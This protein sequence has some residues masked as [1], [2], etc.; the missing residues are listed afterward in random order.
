MGDS[1]FGGDRD[2]LRPAKKK[3][4]VNVSNTSTKGKKK[5]AKDEKSSILD[6]SLTESSGTAD[7]T[8]SK[9]DPFS[10][11][12]VA[13]LESHIQ[14]LEEE[15]DALISQKELMITDYKHKEEMYQKQI[16]NL[17]AQKAQM[18]DKVE[19][20]EKIENAIIELFV[21]M[22]DRSMENPDA[23]VNRARELEDLRRSSPLI[24]LD[25]LRA[26]L[27]TLLNFKL[28]YEK[29]VR[30]KTKQEKVE[31]YNQFELKNKVQ[32]LQADL[33]QTRML[34]ASTTDKLTLA[35]SQLSKLAQT[36]AKTIEEL[37]KDNL[38]LIE[39]V[40]SKEEELSDLKEKCSVQDNEIRTMTIRLARIPQL[41][42]QIQANLMQH[43]LETQ[44]TQAQ[45]V[46]TVKDMEARLQKLVKLENDNR[47]L[48]ERLTK[49]DVELQSYKAHINTTKVKTMEQQTQRLEST[50]ERLT[51]V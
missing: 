21:D 13:A 49:A 46:K 18:T 7:K 40:R 25:L 4:P 30:G 24:V 19:R 37:Q 51:Q 26:N 34:L 12:T 35:Q 2:S 1:S 36:S 17:Q 9:G 38:Q 28:D 6:A 42:A 16:D 10:W 23:P 43:Q 45:S 44:K 29:E 31:D 27:K 50:V 41:E 11:K 32:E 22:K 39:M 20:V 3:A 15:R 14:E 5:T 8:S 48:V 47:E 33:H